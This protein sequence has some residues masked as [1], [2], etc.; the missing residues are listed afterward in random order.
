MAA[1]AVSPDVFGAIADPRRRRILDLLLAGERPVAALVPPLGITMGAV[2]QHLKVLRD[3]G[4]VHCRKRGRQ[5]IYRVDPEPL[6][7]VLDW[8]EPYARFWSDRLDRLGRHLDE[9]P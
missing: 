8:A 5:R 6:R 3:C 2:S 1:P 9:T 7:E 4:L